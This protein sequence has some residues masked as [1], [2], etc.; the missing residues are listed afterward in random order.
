MELNCGTNLSKSVSKPISNPPNKPLTNERTISSPALGNDMPGC[1]R[2]KD[3]SSPAFGLDE[4]NAI[5]YML[6][7]RALG[8][9]A[10]FRGA[11]EYCR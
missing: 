10:L 2:N 11:E 1:S 7:A 5:P 3:E 4:G 8:C 9:T 6:R